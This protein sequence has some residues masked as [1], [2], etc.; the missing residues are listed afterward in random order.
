M[1][2]DDGNTNT[3]DLDSSIAAKNTEDSH[4]I[5]SQNSDNELP[6]LASKALSKSCEVLLNITEIVLESRVTYFYRTITSLPTPSFSSAMDRHIEQTHL[7]KLV[8]EVNSSGISHTYTQFTEQGE[9]WF[10][11]LF[12]DLKLIDN[13]SVGSQEPDSVLAFNR[14]MFALLM[15]KNHEVC[16]NALTYLRN[17]YG[18][19]PLLAVHDVEYLILHHRILLF[20]VL[21]HVCLSV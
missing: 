12:T 20:T 21:S 17:Y 19:R 18:I 11:K 13:S 6:Y 2:D 4:R 7:W 9:I 5:F 10:R 14:H 15:E 16:D 8:E 1:N 3:F